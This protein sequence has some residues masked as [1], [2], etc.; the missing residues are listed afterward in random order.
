MLIRSI[1]FIPSILF[2]LSKKLRC[3]CLCDLCALC[4]EYLLS[5]V[6]IQKCPIAGSSSPVARLGGCRC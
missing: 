1:L 4:G 2:I 3:D 6:K 5:V